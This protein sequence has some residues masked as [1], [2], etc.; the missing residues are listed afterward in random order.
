M[1]L[2][3]ATFLCIMHFFFIYKPVVVRLQNICLSCSEDSNSESISFVLVV[4]KYTGPNSKK[5]KQKDAK[6]E[7]LIINKNL[8]RNCKLQR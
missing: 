8:I 3:S 4:G 5:I 2:F 7:V 1:S 6:Y